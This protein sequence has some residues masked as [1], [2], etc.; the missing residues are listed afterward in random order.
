MVAL[1]AMACGIVGEIVVRILGVAPEMY[2]VRRGRYQISDNPKIGYELVPHFESS[3]AGSMLDFAGRA[4]SLG[5]R[6]REHDRTKPAGTYRI[7]V[8]GDSITQGLGIKQDQD[9]YTSVLERTLGPNTEV[10]NFGVSGYNTQQEVETLRDRG[11]QYSPDLVVLSVC[12]ND[13]ESRSGG[14]LRRLTHEREKSDRVDETPPVLTKSALARFLIAWL[15]VLQNSEDETKDSGFES[16]KQNTM[17]EYFG[18]LA[19]LSQTHQFEV[20]VTWFPR[21]KGS[22]EADNALFADVQ[23][24]S[25]AASFQLLD[26]TPRF[27]TCARDEDIARDSLH[28]NAHGHRCAGEAIAH[29]ISSEIM[30]SP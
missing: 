14:I 8:L 18:I 5:F 16:I 6:D 28:P 24:M 25:A 4:N 22:R 17:G 26:L 19:D 20:L 9:L 23:R 27:E 29:H 21:L 3:E 7:L 1:T 12:V 13:A 15:Y 2:H 30:I 10:L 11:L